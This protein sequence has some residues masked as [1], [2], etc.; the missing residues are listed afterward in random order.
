MYRALSTRNTH[1]IV[2]DGT[3]QAFDGGG[4]C[5]R[6]PEQRGLGALHLRHALRQGGKATVH[7]RRQSLLALL[8]YPG[9]VLLT[10]SGASMVSV[11][12]VRIVLSLS[13]SMY[14]APLT[15]AFNEFF[16]TRVRDSAEGF[17]YA[18]GISVFSGFAH[19]ITTY[20]L[21]ATAASRQ[22]S[23]V[24]PGGR[25]RRGV[26]LVADRAVL[27]VVEDARPTRQPPGG[28]S[29]PLQART[30]CLSTLA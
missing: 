16:P 3:A 23:G 8:S 7:A 28:L 10:T 30:G 17:G 27:S 2:D 12:A 25:R 20:L 4:E 26:R 18:V 22:G 21:G 1:R 6:F 29:P 11:T 14:Q 19:F 13:L 15:A 5:F 9:F 24:H